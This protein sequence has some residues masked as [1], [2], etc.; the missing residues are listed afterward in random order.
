[1]LLFIPD[2][3]ICFRDF[4]KEKVSISFAKL[5]SLVRPLKF[6]TMGFYVLCFM[7]CV[8]NQK[9][10]QKSI[11]A[12]VIN[13]PDSLSLK[14]ACVRIS[15]DL[16]SIDKHSTNDYTRDSSY[17]YIDVAGDSLL[18][19]LGAQAAGPSGA[20]AIIDIVYKTWNIGFDSRDTLV[21]TLLPE[22]VYSRKK[23]AC[24]GVSLVILMLAEKLHCPIRGVMLPGHFFCRFDDGKVRFNIEPNKS[25]FDHPDDYYRRRYLSG[26]KPWY[27]LK[28]IDKKE[29]IG[30]VCFNVGNL[31]LKHKDYLRARAYFTESIRRIPAFIEAKGNLALAYAYGG[32]ISASKLIFDTL[33]SAYP[34]L[35]GLAANYGAVLLA[36]N[37]VGK[38]RKVFTKGLT[39]FSGDSSILSGLAATTR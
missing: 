15:S 27:D 24:L 37:D 29:I 20:R 8:G 16:L 14:N 10:G 25:G 34:D 38:A 36:S 13:L 28:N 12:S 5:I 1:M 6:L 9:N 33:F 4:A 7:A 18:S 19:V 11:G 2:K 23:G 17:R 32:D 26:R 35:N 21:E 3:R 22:L 30:V 39:Y 31:C